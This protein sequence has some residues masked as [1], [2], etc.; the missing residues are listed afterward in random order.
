VL[1]IFFKKNTSFEKM[2]F[3]DF[4]S[5]LQGLFAK[6]K[7]RFIYSYI[8]GK[9]GHKTWIKKPDQ[10]FGAGRIFI[11]DEVRIERGSILYAVKRYG[12]K[13]YRSRINIGRGTFANRHL[14]LTAAF[15]MNIG[16]EVVFGPNVFLTDFDHG[17]E[18]LQK[19]RL[20]T[21]LVSKGPISIGDRCWIGANS[22]IGSGVTLGEGC[23]VAA[24]SVVTRSFPS[25]SVVAGSPAKLIKKYNAD[26][27]HW[28]KVIK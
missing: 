14:N 24:N 12:K 3:Y 7:S 8:F 9:V 4:Y 15:T 19:S 22:F 1:N 26:D 20:D 23:V 28:E 27:R 21:E 13:E 6:I 5:Y 18:D 17:Y 10:V 16:E 11:E 2:D 25:F